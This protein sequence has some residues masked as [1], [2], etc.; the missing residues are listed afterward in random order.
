MVWLGCGELFFLEGG[1]ELVLNEEIVFVGVFEWMDVWVVEW[2]VESLFSCF[3]KIKWV[4][5][6]EIFEIRL[7]MY[8]DMVFIMVNFV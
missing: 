4:L 3:L 8:L 2:F 1:D 7:F 6:V 5:V